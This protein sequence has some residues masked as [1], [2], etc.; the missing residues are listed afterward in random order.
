MMKA[1]LILKTKYV[2]VFEKLSTPV[3][4]ML[5]VHHLSLFVAINLFNLEQG[6]LNK[7]KIPAQKL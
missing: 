1:Q 6:G 2:H 5:L 4:Y 7:A 3:M